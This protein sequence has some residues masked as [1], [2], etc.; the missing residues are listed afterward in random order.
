MRGGGIGAI[1]AATGKL[2]MFCLRTRQDVARLLIA[3]LISGLIE[4]VLGNAQYFLFRS[5]LV[6]ESDGIRRVHAMYGSANSIGLFFDY[7]L[8]IGLALILVK[9]WTATRIRASRL[10]LISV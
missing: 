7:V 4:G 6:L 10:I 3:M 2:A 5:Q 1:F 9:A 8:P